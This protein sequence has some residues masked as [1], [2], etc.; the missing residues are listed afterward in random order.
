MLLVIHEEGK[1][2]NLPLNIFAT[3]EWVRYYGQTD[4]VSGDAI[5]CHPELI[6]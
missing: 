2:I 5:I 3:V 6:R 4:Y 1:L